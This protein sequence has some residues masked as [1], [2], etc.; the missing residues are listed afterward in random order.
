MLFYNVYQL[1]FSF[2]FLDVSLDFDFPF[3]CEGFSSLLLLV[4]VA[5]PF[6]GIV[7]LRAL[8]HLAI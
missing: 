5:A 8:R 2:F 3:F 6:V 4:I 1:F 7:G